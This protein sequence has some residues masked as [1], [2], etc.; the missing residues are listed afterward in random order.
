MVMENYNNKQ[1]ML[2]ERRKEWLVALMVILSPE[3]GG[4]SYETSVRE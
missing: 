4:K 3:E 2:N 1:A